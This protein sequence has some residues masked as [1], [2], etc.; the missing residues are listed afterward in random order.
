MYKLA[1][2]RKQLKENVSEARDKRIQ[3]GINGFKR[4]F[5]VTANFDR[6][7]YMRKY[8]RI[9]W[10]NYYHMRLSMR[11]YDDVNFWLRQKWYMK[12]GY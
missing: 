1:K 8:L 12:H 5:Y 2:F 7:G 6:H 10:D 11:S 3:D 4:C 9:N